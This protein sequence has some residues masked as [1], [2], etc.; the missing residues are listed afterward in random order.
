M[1]LSKQDCELFFSA[2]DALTDYANGKWGV[3]PAVIDPRSGFV[4]E[5]NQR[6]VAA[7]V[8]RNL[9]IIDE[10]LAEEPF[11]VPAQ[12]ADV[13]KAWR[14]AY[15]DSFYV[16][17]KEP[18]VVHFI[19][20]GTAFEVCGLSRE[21]ISM[22]ASMP[23][24]VTATLLPFKDKIVFGVYIEEQPMLFG[25]A[26]AQLI[27]DAWEEIKA[28][29]RILTTADQLIAAVPDLEEQRI[30]REAERM[31]SSLEEEMAP[32]VVG[33][34]AHRGLL[35]DVS[36]GER[37]ELVKKNAYAFAGAEDAMGALGAYCD[38]REPRYSLRGMLEDLG[39]D[40]LLGIASGLRIPLTNM[41][42]ESVV[43]AIVAAATERESVESM[44]ATMDYE[45]YEKVTELY[46]RGGCISVPAD[47]MH[48][49]EGFF[50]EVPLL[51]QPFL[52]DGTFTFV[53]PGEMI[54]ALDE[55]NWEEVGEYQRQNKLLV[56][57]ANFM[58]ELRGICSFDAVYDAYLAATKNPF[59][60]GDAL[61]VLAFSPREDLALYTIW[62]G[63][64]PA[65]T[66]LVHIDLARA[67]GGKD[68]G[69]YPPRLRKDD[70][71][72]EFDNLMDAQRGKSP[73][74]LSEEMLSVGDYVAWARSRPAAIAL[75][76]WLDAHVPDNADDYS[77]ANGV[78]DDLIVMCTQEF[79]MQ[80][81][82]EYLSKNLVVSGMGQLNKVMELFGNLNNTLPRW[83]NNGWA[84][85]DIREG[86]GG[87][88]VFYNEDGSAKRIGPYDLCP[89][90]SGKPYKDCHGRK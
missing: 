9:S 29:G 7:E 60:Q 1:I 5:E 61:S 82:T 40:D 17:S 19:S 78:V 56:S 81:V 45:D 63:D 8:W 25:R 76:D 70:L 62:M 13:L 71:P 24:V 87:A 38:R 41:E 49:T 88:K 11:S 77:Y 83:S 36:A 48:N 14:N 6:K 39:E 68:Q 50:P 43:D 67:F 85:N 2:F 53:M 58:I 21:I 37:E 28:S 79:P 10:L 89:C 64:D 51:C 18:R 75:R 59:D 23:T 66:Y 22:L 90:G 33:E 52:H 44:L 65:N 27:D 74:P 72:M 73:R 86:K 80:V 32:D 26:M 55:T 12:E 16:V 47:Q 57:I 3:A 54:S 84:P 4:N 20:E 34:G 69:P 35:A 30:S 31:L 15:T 46:K 42:R